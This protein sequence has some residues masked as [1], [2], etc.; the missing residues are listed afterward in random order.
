MEDYIQLSVM[1]EYNHVI[2]LLQMKTADT[3]HMGNFCKCDQ[4]L[5]PLF[6]AGCGDEVA[7][8]HINRHNKDLRMHLLNKSSDKLLHLPLKTFLLSFVNN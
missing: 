6:G 2:R 8:S 3:V 5:L 1:L 4:D 7:T